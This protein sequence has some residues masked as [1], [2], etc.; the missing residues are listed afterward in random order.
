MQNKN[1]NQIA[2]Y[3]KMSALY[4]KRDHNKIHVSTY[5][6]NYSALSYSPKSFTYFVL[7]EI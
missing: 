2:F 6:L 4:T 7:A 1:I 3:F 5:I